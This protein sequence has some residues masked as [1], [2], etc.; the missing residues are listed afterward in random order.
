MGVVPDGELP[1]GENDNAAMLT[2]QGDCIF[3]ITNEGLFFFTFS[4]HLN[5]SSVKCL[6]KCVSHFCRGL[7]FFPLIFRSF[8]YM[9]CTCSFSVK[10]TANIFY[11]EACL[12]ILFMETLD[13]HSS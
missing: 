12:S 10:C 4:D 6:F 9:L 1:V 13:E 8:S 7:F 3:L 2:A 11:S 5:S